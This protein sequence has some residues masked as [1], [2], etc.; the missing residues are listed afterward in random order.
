DMMSLQVG[1]VIKTE[2]RM[3][4]PVTLTHQQ[5]TVCHAS[6]GATRSYKSIQITRTS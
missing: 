1:D 2:H 4:T 5:H 6:I 3:T